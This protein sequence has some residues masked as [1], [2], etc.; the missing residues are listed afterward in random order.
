MKI[1]HHPHLLT[2]AFSWHNNP[3]RG[4]RPDPMAERT[5]LTLTEVMSG[6]TENVF[7]NIK[8]KSK[9][10]TAEI[11]VPAGTVAGGGLAKGVT[12]T[13]FINGK[14]AGASRLGR[15]PPVICSADEPADVGMDLATPVVASLGSGSKSK[16][17]AAFRK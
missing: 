6:M 11:E 2:A 15:T 9:A 16:S 17:P 1:F 14:K 13:L 4:G 10:I 5:S 3:P 12:A 7:I 8:N